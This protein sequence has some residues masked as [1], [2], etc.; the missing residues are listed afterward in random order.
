MPSTTKRVRPR[1][2][3]RSKERKGVSKLSESQTGQFTRTEEA[4]IFLISV[5]SDIFRWKGG[6]QWSSILYHECKLWVVY[7]VAQEKCVVTWRNYT[8]RDVSFEKSFRVQMGNKPQ[9][10]KLGSVLVNSCSADSEPAAKHFRRVWDGVGLARALHGRLGIFHPKPAVFSQQCVTSFLPQAT[11]T[12]RMYT[13]W[14]WAR[15]WWKTW[16]NHGKPSWTLPIEVCSATFAEDPLNPFE[17]IFHSCWFHLGTMSAIV[18]YV[19]P[20]EKRSTFPVAFRDRSNTCQTFGSSRSELDTKSCPGPR[21]AHSC[22]LAALLRVSFW[23]Q[24]ATKF[25][26]SMGNLSTIIFIYY[27]HIVLCLINLRQLWLGQVKKFG[28]VR[29]VKMTHAIYCDTEQLFSKRHQLRW[30]HWW[31]SAP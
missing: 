31:S 27:M 21:A 6:K 8:L 17:S 28:S 1:R 11:R 10:K 2:I 25:Y 23:L 7:S 4:S 18:G 15:F 29:H 5:Y 20:V 26:T 14:S 3:G 24:D 22:V 12:S 30:Y 13:F 9:R 19:L 16:E